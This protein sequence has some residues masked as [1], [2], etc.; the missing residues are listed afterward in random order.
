[1]PMI[2][3]SDDDFTK[4]VRVRGKLESETG[5]PRS[6]G[7]IF[8][9]MVDVFEVSLGEPKMKLKTE[10]AS[11]YKD[12]QAA[13]CSYTNHAGTPSLREACAVFKGTL[14]DN[15]FAGGSL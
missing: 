6:L 15:S 9:L 14:T 3:V 12:T 13:F 8:S 10:A 4:L 5:K 7:E 11:A 2:R 1:M